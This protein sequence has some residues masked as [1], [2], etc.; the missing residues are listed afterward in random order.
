MPLSAAA[1][2][3]V[4]AQQTGEVFLAC[5]TI[6]HP[7]LAT[8]IRIVNDRQ[9]LMRAAGTYIAFPFECPM[10]DSDDQKLPQ[11]EIRIDNVD[12][13][14]TSALRGLAGKPTVTLEIVLADS[15]DTV[16]A[17]PFPFSLFDATYSALV[18]QGRLAFEDMLNEPFPKDSFT[19][20]L[21]PGLFVNP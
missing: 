1:L 21:F 12:R 18:V 6:T 11:V 5:L 17:G 10:P 20:S 2:Q 13:S 8:P 19:P 14:I 9:N 3:A 15:P 7:E 4:L 16:E